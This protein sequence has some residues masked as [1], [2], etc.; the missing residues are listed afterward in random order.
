[1]TVE[2]VPAVENNNVFNE[3]L[4]LEEPEV[5]SASD[6]DS[7]MFEFLEKLNIKVYPLLNYLHC[8]Y[9]HYSFNWAS[10]RKRSWF[11]NLN[12]E[13][14][15]WF[16]GFHWDDSIGTEHLLFVWFCISNLLLKCAKLNQLIVNF[17]FGKCV[18]GIR[19]NCQK[20]RRN[21][22]GSFTWL[23][24]LL[25]NELLLDIYACYQIGLQWW[26]FGI[27]WKAFVECLMKLSTIK[28][29]LSG[30]LS[31]LGTSFSCFVFFSIL[32]FILYIFTWLMFH[33]S[34]WLRRLEPPF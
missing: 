9:M 27:Q 18:S 3:K 14:D 32:G 10:H 31:N 26:S 4:P 17:F 30:Y 19:M 2:E 33:P 22:L 29:I 15:G 25:K 13:N 11:F 5:E 16:L 20:R 8:L 23:F 7:Q 28:S 12:T 1:M 34:L 6:E 24:M 21:I